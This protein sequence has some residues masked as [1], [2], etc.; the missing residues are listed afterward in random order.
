MTNYFFYSYY[1]PEGEYCKYSTGQTNG[2]QA[3][4][5]NS[6]ETEPI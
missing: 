3:F 5:Y 2:L 4:G 6:A 1:S